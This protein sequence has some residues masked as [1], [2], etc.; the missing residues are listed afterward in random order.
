MY[1]QIRILLVDDSPY[2]LDAACDFLQ[3][4]API[5]VVGTAAGSTDALAQSQMLQPDVILLDL[6]LEQTSGLALIPAFKQHLPATKIIV[7]TMMEE[8]SYRTAALQAGADG[9]VH[10]SSMVKTLVAAIH[11][12]MRH[13]AA[14]EKT[15]PETEAEA[16]A[17]HPSGYLQRLAEHLPDLLYRYEFKPTRGFTYVSSSATAMTGYTPEEHYADPDLG[18]KL[19][20]PADRHLLGQV[21]HS[22]VVEHQLLELRWIHK[23]GTVLWTEQKNV[24]IFD[25]TGELLAI[26]GVARD[27][28]ARKRT[29][30][31]LRASEHLAQKTLDALA[32]HIAI[33]DE[34]GRIV[35]VN[36]SWRD[37]AQAN[38]IDPALASEGVNYLAVC[39]AAVGENAEEA[40]ATAAGIRAVL[41][42][43]VESYAVEYP[44]HAPAEQRWF[45][46]R[47]TRFDSQASIR[48]A[49][50]HENITERKQSEQAVAASEARYRR[51]FE[52]NPH[53]MW[54]YDLETLR[55][56]AV[57]D[58]AVFH[59]GYSRAE[60][61]AMTLQQIRPDGEIPTLLH[62]VAT[63]TATVQHSGIWKHRV[64]DGRLIDVEITSHAM[65]FEGRP[66][67]LVLSHDITER[68]RAEVALRASE[69]R[70]R[71]TFEQAAVGI[72][73][74]ATDG[75][76]LRVNQRLCEIVGYTREELLGLTFQD[77]THPDDLSIDLEHVR[78]VLADEI[79]TYSLE[80]RYIRKDKTTV[81]INLTVSLLR[82][83]EGAPAYFISIVQDISQRKEALEKLH[84]SE[85]RYRSL[86]EQSNDAVFMLDLQGNHLMAN[87]RA[88]E[89][90]GY[91]PEEIAQL[92]YKDLSANLSR[93]E[94][95]LQQ[96]FAGVHVPTYESRFRRKNGQVFAVEVNV[97]LVRSDHGVPMHIQSIVRD[98]SER[99]AAEAALHLQ[100]SALEAAAN[101]I[102]ITD[103]NGVIQW[104]NSAFTHLTGYTLQE[105]TGQTP[106]LMSSG[107]HDRAFYEGLWNTILAGSPWH[108]EL[109]NKRKDGSL[110]HEEQTITPIADPSGTITHFIG[111]K[112]DI[113]SH[114]RVEERIQ[115]QLRRL[116]ALR[117]IDQAIAAN[118]ALGESLDIVLAKVVELLAMD[119]AVILLAD[120][121][122]NRLE[123]AASIGFQGDA[124]RAANIQIGESYAG[125][126]A[127]ERRQ[128]Q[129]PDLA[130]DTDQVLMN[131]LL[132]DEGF[133]SYHG[134]PLLIKDK[135]VGVL[136]VFNRSQVERDDEWFD[137]L[138]ML[139]GQAAIA[140]ENARLHVTAQRE[141]DERTRAEAELRILNKELE[142]RVEQR[143]ADLTRL[144]EELERALR[145]KDEF[146]A[147][148]SHELR[149]PLSSILGLAEILLEEIRG[150]LNASQRKLISTIQGSGSHLLSLINDVLDLSKIEAEKLEI[151]FER[152][153]VA[154]LSQAS[155]VFIKETAIKKNIKVTFDADPAVTTLQAD[156]RRLKQILVNLLSNAVKFTPTGGQVTLAVRA[157]LEQN[158]IHFAVRDN[159]IGIAPEDLERLFQ[160]FTQVDTSLT[161]RYEGTGLGL[162]LV[163]RLTE[164]HGG[165]LAVESTP[166]LGSCFTV[167]L[168]W[169]P[170]LP[171]ETLSVPAASLEPASSGP[172]GSVRAGLGPILFADDNEANI[173]TIGDYL[174]AKGY[175]MLYA[176]NGRE[177]LE[178]AVAAIP[179]LILMDIQMPEIDGL[180]V[181]RRL[182]ANPRFASLPIIALTALAMDG[183]RERCL[184]AGATTYLSKPVR[185][186]ELAELVGQLLEAAA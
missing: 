1:N 73:H 106:R 11:A 185:L 124:V 111:I 35:A 68:V 64:K 15:E 36:R 114:K 34:T 167:S 52:A 83:A 86:F 145:I 42:G 141:L 82:N 142:A 53:P 177:A 129:I 155:L 87:R 120:A 156:A 172:A 77:I 24:T 117:Q 56:L 13:G 115:Q 153:V 18:F 72:A 144:N 19:V 27:I 90:F 74:V 47:V 78:Q 41:R 12:A 130:S 80:K 59:Y 6:N 99:K 133:I 50:A 169:Q 122:L 37:F 97:E 139:A 54:V 116:A 89:M 96:L 151:N 158:L 70:F 150:P 183:D 127:L 146:L 25:K 49:V 95:V 154:D 136:E 176:R 119:A 147:N 157:D 181:I 173:M 152:L 39:D 8:D 31:A 132:K 3:Y 81:W 17:G 125:K 104:V 67:R 71:V 110:Y 186:R 140:V 92:S 98:I 128:V 7:L 126:A 76:W 184:E 175:R 123:Y 161:R 105:A 134:A 16:S 21:V 40:P 28:T 23:N 33:L 63:E 30:D 166:G 79:Q 43:E 57:N 162:A 22:N 101:A 180:E 118:L 10:K 48:V 121:T 109:I 58:T 60:F 69:E 171:P 94:E 45:V 44:C 113:T 75:R 46:V 164:L 107:K 174:E 148:M 4:H 61:L 66:A 179:N 135:V 91:S 85:A 137:F 131:D 143:T 62:N 138:D 102:V 159:G 38:G 9:F 103:D 88:C 51:L 149:T 182:R 29:E 2:F 112:Q 93:S 5:T 165:H 14:T 160:P 32:A 65:Q 100:G 84:Q 178:Q 168:P 170:H 20:H 26:E 108:G 55:F 163:K